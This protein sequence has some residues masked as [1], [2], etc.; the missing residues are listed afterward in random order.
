MSIAPAVL[1]RCKLLN[2]H[3]GHAWAGLRQH[4]RAGTGLRFRAGLGIT[5]RSWAGIGFRWHGK[6]G[7][8]GGSAQLSH[9]GDRWGTGAAGWRL[10]GAWRNTS[11]RAVLGTFGTST[12]GFPRTAQN[13]NC[14]R[15]ITTF[16]LCKEA[17]LGS[18]MR[19]LV[20]P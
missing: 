2:L 9:I 3:T 14:R 7:E 4:V 1:R 15:D 16:S 5:H 12:V 18:A 13:E 10:D 17:N 20:C 19:K 11:I 8:R 6:A